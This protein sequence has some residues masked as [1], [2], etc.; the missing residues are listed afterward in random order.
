MLV[1]DTY[2]G[3]KEKKDIA[4]RID[5]RDSLSVTLSDTDR[6]RS[7][8][9]TTTEDGTDL[10]IVISEVLSDGDVL[11]ADDRPIVVS[12]EDVDAMV[13]TFENQ[14]SPTQAVGLGHAIGNRHWDIAV[15]NDHVYVALS[16]TR[17]RMEEFV[18]PLLPE[19][20]SLDY[21]SVPVT[22]FDTEQGHGSD[23]S[24]AID[25]THDE[26]DHDHEGAHSHNHQSA[27]TRA[28]ENEG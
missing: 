3:S 10:G 23:H 9:R 7:R 21:E 13:L 22:T 1:A 12:L 11:L 17:T 16:E 15:E 24:H 18:H 27:G 6:R 19:A 14:V 5:E 25:S 4:T 2:L 8:V 20:C 26:S 28:N